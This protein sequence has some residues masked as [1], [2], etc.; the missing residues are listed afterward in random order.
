[1]AISGLGWISVEPFSQSS[2]SSTPSG[3]D[4]GGE[5]GLVVH[6]P[7]PVEIFIRPPLPVDTAGGKWYEYR[8]LTEMEQEVRPRWYF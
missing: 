7:K 8:E 5:I 1:M 3:A 4:A 2:T 6:V